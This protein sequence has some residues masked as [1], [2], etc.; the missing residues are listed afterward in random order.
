MKNKIFRSIPK[1]ANNLSTNQFSKNHLLQI[2]RQIKSVQR[3]Q[4]SF[5]LMKSQCKLTKAQKRKARFSTVHA[6]ST[7][8]KL[9]QTLLM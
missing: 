5:K 1:I 7:S 2:I 8:L 9:K 6:A 4:N 3:L